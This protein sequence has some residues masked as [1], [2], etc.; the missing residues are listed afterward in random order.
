M[1][2]W[3]VENRYLKG[4]TVQEVQ[5]TSDPNGNGSNSKGK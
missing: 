2:Q 4:T 3:R 1:A 5:Y